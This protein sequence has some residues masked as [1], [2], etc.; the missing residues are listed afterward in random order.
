MMISWPRGEKRR[1][2]CYRA[3]NITG[4]Y[5]KKVVLEDNFAGFPY[6]GQ[7]AL[8]DDKFGNW[9]AV[10]FQDRGA[11]G[12]VPLLMPCNW[13][14]GWPMLGDVNGKVPASFTTPFKTQQV[15]S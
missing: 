14:E 12:R 6:V 1:Q 10:I 4:P 11:I 9:Y 13:V 15:T 5:E 2:V 3:D 8:I 7:G